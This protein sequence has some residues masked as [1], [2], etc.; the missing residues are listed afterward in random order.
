MTQQNNNMFK[1][2]LSLV[3]I[4]AFVLSSCASTSNNYGKDARWRKNLKAPIV[5]RVKPKDTLYS[6]AW[7]YGLDYREVAKLNNLDI[8]YHIKSG[9]KLR[10]LPRKY[11]KEEQHVPV[12]IETVSDTE[13]LTGTGINQIGNIS[14]IWP[15]KGKVINNFSPA[16]LNKGI[17][18]TGKLG[19]SVLAA[20]NGKVVYSSNGL[21]GYGELIIIKHSDEFLSAYAHN[22]KLFVR[23]GQV[24]KAG[25]AIAKMGNTE[26][27]SVILH[28]E[29]RKAG[30]PVDPLQYLPSTN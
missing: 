3:I 19:S 29:I 7:R 6:I 2:K 13:S 22:Q 21:R 16:G 11:K 14:W 10:L 24:V 1:S 15:A 26:A 8:S 9:Q 20:A 28:F 18:I 23:E 17:D 5:Y 12:P 27:S 4:V 25:Q 30:R